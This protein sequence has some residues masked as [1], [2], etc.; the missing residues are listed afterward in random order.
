MTDFPKFKFA[1]SKEYRNRA[2]AALDSKWGLMIGATVA[3]YAIIIAVSSIFIRMVAG[4]APS[5]IADQE[6]MISYQIWSNLATLV[7]SFLLLPLGYG[8]TGMFFDLKRAW[9]TKFSNLFEGY[10]TMIAP[11]YGTLLL[12]FLYTLLWSLLFIIPGIIKSYS[13][14]MTIFCMKEDPQYG[15]YNEAIERSMMI[16]EGNKMRLFLLDLSFIGWFILGLIPCGLGLFF[17]IPYWQT[18]RMEFYE[19][20]MEELGYQEEC[21]KQLEQQKLKMQE[22]KETN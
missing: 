15:I 17:V 5:N 18:A 12:Q 3:Y 8:F 14:A 9:G 10:G 13:Y 7:A 4:P 16:M 21:E 6:A 2:W 20:L 11:V 19:D 1:T 22:D